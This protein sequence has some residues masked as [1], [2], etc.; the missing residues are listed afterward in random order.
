MPELTYFD[1]NGRADYAERLRS[2]FRKHLEKNGLRLT[3]Q[4]R[5]ILDFMLRT[6]RH[7]SLQEIYEA[8][9]KYGIGRVTVFRTLKMLEQGR[10]ADRISNAAGGSRFE[11]RLERPHHD[12]L[13]CIACGSIQEVRWP[14]LEQIQEKA[15][16]DRGFE[17]S[18]H[19][20]E[21]FGR[22]SRCRPR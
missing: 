17:I 15:C 3:S 16:R 22:C 10:L 6:E 4:R 12:H 7:V 1:R 20:H 13:I 8:V 14:Q 2:A 9:R 11:I 21:I 19:R 18:W 5:R